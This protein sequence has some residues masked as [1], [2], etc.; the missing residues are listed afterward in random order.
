MDNI[1]NFDDKT[2]WSMRSEADVEKDEAN[3]PR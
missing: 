2:T 3:I 1:H